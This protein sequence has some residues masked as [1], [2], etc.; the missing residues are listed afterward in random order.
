MRIRE[1]KPFSSGKRQKTKRVKG[2]YHNPKM[3]LKI[4]LDSMAHLRNV[5]KQTIT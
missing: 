5:E 2:S 1:K 3:G 4:G